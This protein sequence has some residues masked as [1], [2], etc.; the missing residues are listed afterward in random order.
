MGFFLPIEG[1]HSNAPKFVT[2]ANRQCSMLYRGG[3]NWLTEVVKGALQQQSSITAYW[4]GV[5]SHPARF[6]VNSFNGPEEIC[7]LTRF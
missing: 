4:H 6:D 5:C 3:Y 1:R 2:Q 7:E